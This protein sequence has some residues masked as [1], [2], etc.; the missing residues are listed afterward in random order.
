M[1]GP[2]SRS[3]IPGA[4]HHQATHLLD[5]GAAAD[6]LQRSGGGCGAYTTT[7][8]T[9]PTFFL[10]LLLPLPSS[11]GGYW[12]W[13][14]P[15][16]PPLPVVPIPNQL[17]MAVALIVGWQ[18]FCVWPSEYTMVPGHITVASALVFI[19]LGCIVCV[20]H[21]QTGRAH[22]RW[23]LANEIMW[24]LLGIRQVCCCTLWPHL[25]TLWLS[26]LELLSF[27]VVKS[28]RLIR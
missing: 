8:S 19:G 6:W 7:A 14:G 12:L 16:R 27:L 9:P 21:V 2:P 5:V 25:C 24:L 17:P 26:H 3:F 10:L 11:L 20:S 23:Q 18:V 28:S 13:G 4:T 15:T 22:W 1:D